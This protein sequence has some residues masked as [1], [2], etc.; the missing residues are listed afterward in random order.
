MTPEQHKQ[1]ERLYKR[2]LYP[3]GDKKPS[4]LDALKEAFE[5]GRQSAAAPQ[6]QAIQDHSESFTGMLINE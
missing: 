1:L 2:W 5:L 3:M 6:V 4:M